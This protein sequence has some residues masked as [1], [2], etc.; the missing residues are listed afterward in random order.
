MSCRVCR[1]CTFPDDKPTLYIVQIEIDCDFVAN[2]IMKSGDFY[3]VA[4]MPELLGRWFTRSVV[5]PA[6][7]LDDRND[8]SQYR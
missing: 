6:I 3:K 2:C 4:I 5:L 8:D 1:L 7:T